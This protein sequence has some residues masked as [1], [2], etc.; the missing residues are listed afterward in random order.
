MNMAEPND[1]SMPVAKATA[2]IA[3]AAGAQIVDAGTQATSALSG[4][5]TLTWPNL[6][7]MAAFL[8]S[9]VLLTEFCWKKFWRPALERLGWIKAKS[10]RIPTPSEWAEL[11]PHT[12]E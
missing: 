3:T 9:L 10:R 6:A 2:S 11:R 5:L 8:Y 7:A 4:L 1:I 12:E